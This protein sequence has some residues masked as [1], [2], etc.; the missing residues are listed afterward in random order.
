MIKEIKLPEIA[1]N[2][3]LATVVSI[4]VSVGDSVSQDD[5]IA[6]MESD[7]AVFDMPTDAAG[8]VKEIKV[9][10]GDEVKVGQ[11]VL[12]IDTDEA[13]TEKNTT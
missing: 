13:G 12:L 2:I 6:E 10:S 9:K 8:T 5:S 4:H 11:V 3:D 1:D 7:K